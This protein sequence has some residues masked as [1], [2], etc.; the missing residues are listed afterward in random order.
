METDKS[1]RYTLQQDARRLEEMASYLRQMADEDWIK[2]PD[3]QRLENE[4]SLRVRIKYC[5]ETLLHNMPC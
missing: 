2:L 4:R 5:I 3:W 1:R